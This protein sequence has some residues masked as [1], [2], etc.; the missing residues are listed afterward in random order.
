MHKTLHPIHKLLHHLNEDQNISISD[1][2]NSS[3][4]DISTI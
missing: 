1:D 3:K 4:N 2:S